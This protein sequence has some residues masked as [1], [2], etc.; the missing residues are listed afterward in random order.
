MSAAP[1][2]NRDPNRS[3]ALW[4]GPQGFQESPR[5][6]TLPC[7]HLGNTNITLPAIYRDPLPFPS[8]SLNAC[9]DSPVSKKQRFGGDDY[10]HTSYGSRHDQEDGHGSTFAINYDDDSDS[11]DDRDAA[12]EPASPGEIG[13]AGGGDGARSG[14]GGVR[15]SKNK[16]W[17]VHRRVGGGSMHNANL[18]RHYRPDFRE[19][20]REYPGQKQSVRPRQTIASVIFDFRCS[21]GET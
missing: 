17:K 6:P 18:Y 21:M 11:D 16:P 7:Q 5:D 1:H 3:T 10:T 8:C 15:K 14:A 12:D 20:A 9:T 4:L 13:G 19:L 2:G